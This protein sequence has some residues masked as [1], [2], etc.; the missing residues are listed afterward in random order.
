MLYNAN[1]R[2]MLFIVLIKCHKIIRALLKRNEWVV[3]PEFACM[4]RGVMVK[5]ACMNRGVMLKFACMDRDSRVKFFTQSYKEYLL[6]YMYVSHQLL[7]DQKHI[8]QLKLM[9]LP[10]TA[11]KIFIRNM[12]FKKM[13]FATELYQ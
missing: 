1:I 12:L 9:V 4:N 2:L 7:L 5:F 13:W 8:F 3:L 10:K 6:M 11:N